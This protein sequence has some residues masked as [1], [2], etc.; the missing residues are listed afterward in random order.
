MKNFTRIILAVFL[1]V[2]GMLL[3]GSCTKEGGFSRSG[4]LIRFGAVNP[5][6]LTKTEYAGKDN[7]ANKIE[8]IW[9]KEGDEIRVVSGDATVT[10]HTEH[11]ADYVFSDFVGGDKSKA[12]V[13][14]KRGKGLAWAD[15]VKP[16][17]FYAVYPSTVNIGYTE[18][19]LG[20]VQAVIP[21]PQTVSAHEYSA[22]AN[23]TAKDWYNVVNGKYTVYEPDMKYAFMTAKTEFTPTD[24]NFDAYRYLFK[25]GEKNE[26]DEVVG[27][28]VPLTFYPAFTA[29][30][31]TFESAD[32]SV[33]IDLTE[34][35][36]ESI[37]IENEGSVTSAATALAGAFT[38]K[39]GATGLTDFSPMQ[40]ASNSLSLNNPGVL[41]TITYGNPKSFTVFAMP[42]DLT[43]LWIFFTDE[44][45]G[46]ARTR[47]LSLTDNA[48]GKPIVFDAGKKYRI[49]GLKLPGN[50]YQFFLTLNGVVQQWDAVTLKTTFTEQIQCSALTFNKSAREMTDEYKAANGGK[51]NHYQDDAPV[52][53]NRW[54]VRTLNN[55]NM[56]GESYDYITAQFT[57]TAPLGGYWKLELFNEDFWTVEIENRTSPG[58]EP[59]TQP[60]PAYGQ[61]L[62][63]PVY[64][65]FTPKW[66]AI[67]DAEPGVEV[68]LYMNCFF[69]GD[70]DFTNILDAN[71]EFQDIHGSGTYSYWLITVAR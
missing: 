47:K 17:T 41:G 57:P 14:N 44:D 49:K 53:D 4:Q 54:Q 34:F 3:A 48:S 50:Q 60:L 16:Y 1:L 43:N 68:G 32:S 20:L 24:A 65:R 25:N 62:N 29:F 30:E 46:Q 55:N 33:P 18:G 59:T 56:D 67:D 66:S 7:D 22:D 8:P 51:T 9:W 71:T 23:G 27:P 6:T 19:N 21:N 2:G 42:Q 12:T 61:I 45:G 69:S 64:L 63:T 26:N 39:P 35:R 38:G 5:G 31:F 15:E 52:G 70:I 11:Y 37:A 40:T 58:D 36:M 28:E 13:S 10:D